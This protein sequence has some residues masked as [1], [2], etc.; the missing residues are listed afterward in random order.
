MFS[1]FHASFHI[2]SVLGCVEMFW[3][4]KAMGSFH[5]TEVIRCCVHADDMLM[6][7]GPCNFIN[8]TSFEKLCWLFVC[9]VEG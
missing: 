2:C 7:S 6:T 3:L 5:L 1:F 9:Y 4:F 8:L